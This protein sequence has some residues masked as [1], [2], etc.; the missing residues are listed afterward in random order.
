ML[1]ASFFETY[2][3]NL[4]RS[5]ERLVAISELLQSLDFPFT[6]VEAVDARNLDPESWQA[7]DLEACRRMMGR[8]LS[9]GELACFLSHRKALQSIVSGDAPFGLV[10]EDDATLSVNAREKIQLL[11]ETL[12][13]NPG[14]QL[15]L[16]NLGRRA[17]I[18]STDLLFSGNVNLRLAH[19]PPMG[20]FAILWSKHAAWE[21]LQVSQ[22]I[23]APFD[24]ALQ[25]W[26]SR[27]GGGVTLDTPIANVTSVVS[28]IDGSPPGMALTRGS[29]SRTRFHGL[30]KQRRLMRNRMWAIYHLLK[31][32]I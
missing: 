3:I 29:S 15:R 25:N 18:L 6:R 26:L 17:N 23:T 13:E 27:S 8:E 19:Y 1:P 7:V 20:A 31:N 30:T 32:I 12:Y 28:D 9:G 5:T 14:L 16:V 24:N 21:F 10:L 22:R 11:C 4:G 2:V